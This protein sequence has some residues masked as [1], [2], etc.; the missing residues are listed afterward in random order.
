ME[1]T[2]RW[3]V[4]FTFL[5]LFLATLR[6][7]SELGQLICRISTSLRRAAYGALSQAGKRGLD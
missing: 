5:W 6:R 2:W 3:A 1:A 4:L 7:P